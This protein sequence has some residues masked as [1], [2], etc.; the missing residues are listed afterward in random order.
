MM[1][2]SKLLFAM[3]LLC[4]GLAVLPEVARSQDDPS[5]STRRPDEIPAAGQATSAVKAE[6]PADDYPLIIPGE[7]LTLERAVAIGR[8]LQPEVLA[9]QGRVRVG[10]S[11]VGQARADYYPRIDGT[12]AY[13]RISPALPADPRVD[14][15]FNQYT[16]GVT[17]DQLI[18]DFGRTSTRVEIQKSARDSYRA[19][20][21]S[22]DDQVIFNVILAYYD[23]LRAARNREV[24][25]ETV[26]QFERHLEQAT[27]FFQAGLRPRYDVTRAEV[28]LSNARLDLIRTENSLRLARV[29]LNNAMGL[30]DAPEYEVEDSLDYRQFDLPLE[31][32]L[33]MAMDNRPDLQ[34]LLLRKRTA[35][36][37]VTLAGKGHYPYLTAN[38][39]AYLA[40][41]RADDLNEGWEAGV[42]FSV[43]IFNG[44]LIR[45]RVEEARANLA[46]L[47]ASEQSRRQFID[48][49]VR[50]GY[51]DLQEAGE[52]VRTGELIVRQAE[53][54]YELAAGR[55]KAGV[56]NPIELADAEVILVNA[57]I[58]HIQALYDYRLAQAGIER[59][60][61]ML[62]QRYGK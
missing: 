37:E 16:A 40:G 51:L 25:E 60:I 47:T 30:I 29:V 36:Q 56:G 41:E 1:S 59:A 3:A 19:E 15:S 34:A 26:R 27:G 21:S 32:A 17:A 48:R 13:S 39:A 46:I 54:N 12:A 2:S 45:H 38:A 62:R 23:L 57:R 18:Y 50:M 33:P 8:R 35:E 44:F 28:D 49:E 42:V 53:E 11:R 20:F 7:T 9:A 22:V 31:T 24:T 5:S 52:R 10:E 55:Y 61:G 58:N 43:P 6:S 4:A 14:G